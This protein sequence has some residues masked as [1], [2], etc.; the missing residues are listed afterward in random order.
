MF[1][2]IV[3]NYVILFTMIIFI[4]NFHDYRVLSLFHG[5]L[6]QCLI[7]LRFRLNIIYLT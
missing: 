3:K 2:F 5:Y 6:I 4:K 7:L 1:I